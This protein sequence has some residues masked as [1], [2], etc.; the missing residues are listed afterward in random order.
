MFREDLKRYYS[1]WTGLIRS[2]L[3]DKKNQNRVKA[4]K[5]SLICIPEAKKN[6]YKLIPATLR[7]YRRFSLFMKKEIPL[8][9]KAGGKK[10]FTVLYD[11]N[12]ENRYFTASIYNFKITYN[13]KFFFHPME[14]T[15]GKIILDIIRDGYPIIDKSESVKALLMLLRDEKELSWQ[16]RVAH[17]KNAY[18]YPI[19][20][21][22]GPPG[23]GK[24]T[25]CIK[26]INSPFWKTLVLS[27][28]NQA[29]DVLY[30][31]LRKETKNVLRIGRGSRYLEAVTALD[32]ADSEKNIF[33]TTLAQIFL[34]WQIIQD[35]KIH[36]D[37][38]FIDE[39]GTVKT[40]DILAIA[41]LN[42]DK[43]Y[44]VGDFKQLGPITDLGFN[45][46]QKPLLPIYDNLGITTSKNPKEG[47]DI[48]TMLDHQFRMNRQIGEFINKTFYG[49]Q[50]LIENDGAQNER[51]LNSRAMECIDYS[52]FTNCVEKHKG[53]HVNFPSAVL[54]ALYAV[55]LKEKY[56]CSV[57][58][59]TPYKA[60]RDLISAIIK[61]YKENSR[62]RIKVET[63]HGFQGSEEDVIIMDFVDSTPLDSLGMLFQ[64]TNQYRTGLCDRMLNVAVSRARKKFI[65]LCDNSFFS[66]HMQKDSSIEKLIEK[67]TEGSNNLKSF[68]NMIHEI[69]SYF[70][71]F[72][73]IGFP[74][75][76][77]NCKRKGDPGASSAWK[78]RSSMWRQLK[79]DPGKEIKNITYYIGTSTSKSEIAPTAFKKELLQIA[80][81]KNKKRFFTI[82]YGKGKFKL[83]EDYLLRHPQIRAIRS[84]K[85]EYAISSVLINFSDGKKDMIYGL[86]HSRK[87]NRAD[88]PFIRLGKNKNT[89]RIL[90]E[91]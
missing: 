57:G 18:S 11:E 66:E 70:K 53:S 28:T 78:C 26:L 4:A 2:S 90:Y 76:S 82:R 16:E 63:V 83:S 9:L 6:L 19:N 14:S 52:F 86:F 58:V 20:F 55:I 81:E 23:S 60:Q 41:F 24:S 64:E 74:G 35:S 84:E 33:C 7:D 27:S 87:E 12:K 47:C 77:V 51:L 91:E 79:E 71:D 38:I 75:K 46:V 34:N 88:L 25:T 22:W 42:P 31:K 49:G 43:M 73:Q 3:S 32:I 36:F 37:Y 56:G 80:A 30:G 8:V 89:V 21:I 13:R 40:Q 59:I 72:I 68:R 10:Y 39:A 29:V 45:N 17:I 67:C 48:F 61:D 85:K 65:L 15:L 1:Y 44:I 50:L 5:A 62:S 69:N 54:A